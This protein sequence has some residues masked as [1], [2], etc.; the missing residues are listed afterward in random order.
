MTRA[1]Q[2]FRFPPAMRYVPL[3]IT[4]LLDPAVFAQTTA[5]PENV[6]ISSERLER[7]SKLIPDSASA[8]W[9]Y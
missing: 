7:L 8:V 5:T 6:G 4:F 2:L 3:L 9:W 1:L